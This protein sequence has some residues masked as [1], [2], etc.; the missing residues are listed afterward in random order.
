MAR[1]CAASVLL[2]LGLAAVT[3]QLCTNPAGKRHTRASASTKQ[4]APRT[5]TAASS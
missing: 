3:A 5:T 1:R 2:L 4:H